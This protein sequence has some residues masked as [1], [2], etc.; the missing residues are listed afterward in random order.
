MKLAFIGGW[1]HAYLKGLL[2]D[3]KVDVSY[4]VA[5]AGD[6]KD[7]ARAQAFTRKLGVPVEWFD[8]ARGMLDK[9]KPD[10]VNVGTVY[11]YAG[12]VIATVLERGVPVVSD[13]PIAATWQQLDRLKQLTKN[14][15]LITEFNFRSQPEFRAAR[16]AVAQGLVGKVALAT[17]QKSYR[18]GTRPSWYGDRIAYGGTILWV[19]GHGID[20]IRFVTGQTFTRVTGRHKNV[21]HPEMGTMEDH[22]M[23]VFALSGGGTASCHADYL[24]P[25]KAPTHGD[26]RLR[27]IGS[28]G[29]VEVRDGR[30]VLITNDAPAVDITDRAAPQPSYIELLAAVRGENSEIYSTEHSLEMAAVLLHARD[31]ADGEKW[32]DL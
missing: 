1:G 6:G 11:G 25:A 10:A 8:D 4:P 2:T 32:I 27:V 13:K 30:C 15:R 7:N 17:A 20:A 24:R 31:A 9:F 29:V 23:N 19:A 14:A 18:F 12:D 5:V 16:D 21:T 22:T 28:T 26:D 3:K